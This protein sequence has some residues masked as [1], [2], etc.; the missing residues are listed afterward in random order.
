MDSLSSHPQIEQTLEGQD[1][2]MAQLGAPGQHPEGWFFPDTYYFPRNTTDLAFLRR[3]HE[4]MKA[5]LDTL[6]KNRAQDLPLQTPYE[7]LI[8]ASIVEKETA[9]PE[10][11]PAIA[12]VFLSRLRQ[13]MPLQADPTV[14]YGLGESF[15]GDI[16]YSDLNLDTPYNTYIHKGLTPTPIA[17]PGKAALKAVLH[18]A[19]SDAL[20]FV[21]RRDG[22]HHFS[23]TYEEHRKAVIEHQ[24]DGD[25]GRYNTRG[26]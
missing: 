24:L 8:L 26:Q 10:E 3:S 16:G 22:R 6:W 13:G 18:P 12:A 25:A 5:H 9:A 19:R 4:M 11:R 7:A 23:A 14:I 2:V 21:A 1:G 20:Y 15:D 17:M